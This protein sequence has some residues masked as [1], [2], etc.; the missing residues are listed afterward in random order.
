MVPRQD[1][2]ARTAL[3]RDGYRNGPGAGMQDDG[4]IAAFAL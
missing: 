2:A 3:D 4:H 1:K